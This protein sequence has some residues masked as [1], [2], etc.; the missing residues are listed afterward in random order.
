[1]YVYIINLLK[2]LFVVMRDDLLVAFATDLLDSNQL[3]ALLLTS[4]MEK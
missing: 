4:F 2:F 3:M 1:M